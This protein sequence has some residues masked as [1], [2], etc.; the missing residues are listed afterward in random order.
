MLTGVQYGKHIQGEVI[1]F[2]MHECGGC[3]IPFCV[4]TR[5]LNDRKNNHGEYYCPNGCNRWFAGKTEAQKLKEELE[6]IKAD[7][8]ER[9][10]LLQDRWLDALGEKNKLE[11]KLKRIHNGVCPCCNRSF[12]NLKNHIANKHPELLNKKDERKN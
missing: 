9:E 11:K 2:T 3:G 5:W 4:P 1:D 8:V 12:A 6:Q 7:R 10:Q